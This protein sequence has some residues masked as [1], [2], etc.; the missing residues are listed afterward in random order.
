[1][2]SKGLNRFTFHYLDSLDKVDKP[3][4]W[5]AL[6][7]VLKEAKPSKIATEGM[8]KTSKELQ[9]NQFKRVTDWLMEVLGLGFVGQNSYQE[10]THQRSLRFQATTHTSQLEGVAIETWKRAK[11]HRIKFLQK[12]DNVP[13]YGAL[14]T[15]EVDDNDEL[16]AVN[17]AIADSVGEVDPTPKYQPKELKKLIQEQTKRNLENSD[18]KSTLYYYF[19]SKSSIDSTK[20]CWRLV[21]FVENQLKNVDTPFRLESIPEM[22]NYVIDAHTGELVAQIPRVKTIR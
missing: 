3:K 16:L 15:V 22:V 5:D 19:D 11:T 2:N 9:G 12:Y 4:S 17:S 20:G 18:L 13:V 10:Q 7:N 1:M 21:Y 6:A 14:V 8:G